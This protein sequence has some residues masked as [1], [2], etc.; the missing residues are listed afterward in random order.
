MESM[1]HFEGAEQVNTQAYNF[2]SEYERAVDAKGRFNLPFRFRRTMPGPEDEKYMITLGP[3]GALALMPY[4]V[5]LESFNRTQTGPASAEQRRFKRMMSR[6]SHEVTPDS[7]G[8][9][10]VPSRYLVSA[11]IDRKVVVIGVGNYMELWAPEALPDVGES[12][13]EVSEDLTNEFFR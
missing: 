13:L 11:G 6:N 2:N 9:I 12:P 5:W 4:P 1:D 10:A 7:Q 3:D 8:R